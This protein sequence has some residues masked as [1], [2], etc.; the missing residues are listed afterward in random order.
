MAAYASILPPALRPGDTV[1]VVSLS[2]GGAAALPHRYATGKRQLAETFGL[3]VIEAPHATRDSDW[4]RDNPRARAADLHWALENPEV[5]G[6]VSA[7]GGFHALRMLPY[8]DL[9]LIAAHPKVFTG[10]SDTT[11]NHLAFGKAG[12]GSFYG[13]AVLST[14][15]ENG[16]IAEF[17]AESFRATVMSGEP[18]GDLAPAAEWTEE[19]LDWSDPELQSRRRRWVPNYGWLWLQGS[20]PVQGPIMG[21]CLEVLAQAMGTEI[22]PALTDFEGAVLH[23]EISNERPP[24]LQ[25]QVW[26]RQFAALGV[27]ERIS[28]LLFS[29]PEAMSLRETLALY[30]AIRDELVVAGRPDLPFVANLDYGHSSPMGVLP[31]GRQLLVD[32]RQR[33]LSIL[34]PAV[35]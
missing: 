22:W 21:G 5:H 28:A 25:V 35:R 32:P 12:V 30:D 13:M 1:A 24:Q 31:L 11:I 34:E 29:R 18:V 9:D 6:I 7:I 8:L 2:S 15:A 23:L 4:L 26:L 17:S 20:E 3:R 27:L 33:R 16:G 10:Y 14:A 19:L